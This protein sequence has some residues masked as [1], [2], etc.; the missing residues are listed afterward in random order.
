VYLGREAVGQGV[1]AGD[2]D[3]VKASGHLVAVFAELAAG[4]EDGKYDLQCGAVFL[5]VHA[6]RDTA[7]VVAYADGVA[8]QHADVDGVAVACHGF[9][10]TVVDDFVY[11]V[12]EAA[13]RNVAY[14]HRRA[15]ADR[16]E[17]FKYLD[18]VRGILFFRLLHLFLI[19]HC[20]WLSVC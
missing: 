11:E 9:I 13:L 15:L 20:I 1:D 16:F 6:G 14:I 10:Y 12:M 3:A 18:T 8:L 19:N 17:S 5:L 2:A 7:A 4:V